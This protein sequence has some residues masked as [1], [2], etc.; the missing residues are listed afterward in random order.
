MWNNEDPCTFES[1]TLSWSHGQCESVIGNLVTKRIILIGNMTRRQRGEWSG[2]IER[3]EGGRFIARG[4][5][6][7]TKQ[8]QGQGGR[9]KRERGNDV[10]ACCRIVGGKTASTRHRQPQKHRSLTPRSSLLSSFMNGQISQHSKMT[11]LWILSTHNGIDGSTAAL[12]IDKCESGCCH[13]TVLVDGRLTIS[14]SGLVQ[15]ISSQSAL[16]VMEMEG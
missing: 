3:R 12:S 2:Q 7:R 5:G 13:L 4:E 6:Q 9:G 10:A 1:Y 11:P 14:L 16:L 8:K 15:R